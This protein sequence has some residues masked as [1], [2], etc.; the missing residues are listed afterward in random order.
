MQGFMTY[1]PAASALAV[2]ATSGVNMV[3]VQYCEVTKALPASPMNNLKTLKPTLVRTRAVRAIG[4]ALRNKVPPIAHR[5]PYLSQTGPIKILVTAE[6]ATPNIDEVQICS[7]VKF[8]EMAISESNGVNANHVKNATK[9]AI[10]A[11]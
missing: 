10:Q 11:K 6:P 3:D 1:Q 4:M 2:P 5:A 7:L 9:N 8:K